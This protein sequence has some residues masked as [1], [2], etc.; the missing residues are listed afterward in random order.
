MA[1]QVKKISGLTGI[2]PTKI[3]GENSSNNLGSVDVVTT[4]ATVTAVNTAIPTANAV[5]EFVEGK[6][7]LVASNETKNTTGSTDTSEKIFLVGAKTQAAN[8]QTF[9]DD[10]VY[11]TNG[12]LTANKLQSNT[13]YLNST[14]DYITYNSSCDSIDFII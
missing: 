2:T 5:K 13:L 4:A 10:Q 12:T 6:K 8:P 14:T 11:T 7:Y 9:S 3:L 1:V